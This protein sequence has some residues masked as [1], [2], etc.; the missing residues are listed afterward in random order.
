MGDCFNPS[1]LGPIHIT[2][3]LS[4]IRSSSEEESIVST[5]YS[6]VLPLAM[7]GGEIDLDLDLDLIQ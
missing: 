3:M 7:L 2:G 6:A 4:A 1:S 5:V